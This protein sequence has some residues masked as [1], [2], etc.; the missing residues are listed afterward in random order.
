MSLLTVVFVQ[1]NLAHIL[2]DQEI[3]ANDPLPK[4]FLNPIKMLWRDGGVK[5]AI[6]KGNEF[7]LHDN[8]D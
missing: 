3:N 7:A 6:L 8:L 1:K 2:V 4:D 5:R